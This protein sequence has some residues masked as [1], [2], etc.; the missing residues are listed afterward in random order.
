[1]KTLFAFLVGLAAPLAI[2]AA[3]EAEVDTAEIKR[4]G[5]HVQHIDASHRDGPDDE[6]VRV[7]GPP[8]DDS[9]KWFIS[10]IGKK[11]CAACARLKTDFRRDEYLRALV[12]LAEGDDAHSDK[13]SWAHY[14]YFLSDDR[15]QQFRWEKIRVVNFPTVLVQPPLNKKYG[16][17]AT[18][19]FQ[20]TGYDGDGKKL[21]NKI[22]SAIKLYLT[23]QAERRAAA[24][25]SGHRALPPAARYDAEEDWPQRPTQGVWVN[26][27]HRQVGVDPPWDPAPKVDPPAPGP[28]P[29]PAPAPTPFDVLPNIFNVPPATPPATPPKPPEPNKPDLS[30]IAATPELFVVRDCQAELTEE[31]EG[32]LAAIIARL[33]RDRPVLRIRPVDRRDA[34]I[35]IP[36]DQLPA[37]VV[38][39]DGQVQ[40]RVS[41][42]LLPLLQPPAP[43]P[44][45]PQREVGIADLPW[46]SILALLTTGFSIPAAIPLVV[47]GIGFI[48]SR[49]RAAGKPTL[50]SD[51]MLA[52]LPQ[53]LS[54][55]PALFDAIKKAQ[56]KPPASTEGTS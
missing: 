35:D 50:I 27:G 7:M 6:Y 52:Q 33:R 28:G 17:P 19:V 38:T 10:V 43:Q 4:L 26:E 31:E 37:V 49:R 51:E 55:L 56:Q 13:S 24:R 39:A 42:R 40:D 5:D 15:S 16:D 3:Q 18:V 54:Q 32:R 44:P 53:L 12:T 47:W 34:P 9:H 20:S 11:G 23:K 25:S 30:K 22:A 41:A 2:A 21:A 1:M 46:S 14:N 48:R 36:K 29:G 8:E 45:P